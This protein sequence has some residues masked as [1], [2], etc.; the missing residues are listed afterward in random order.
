[1][2]TSTD[3]AGSLHMRS[4]CVPC[5]HRAGRDADDIYA[6]KRN[7]TGVLDGQLSAL[8]HCNQSYVA[9]VAAFL[10]RTCDFE[11]MG[12]SSTLL[13]PAFRGL[14]GLRLGQISRAQIARGRQKHAT[15]LVSSYASHTPLILV[16]LSGKCCLVPQ[17]VYIST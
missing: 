13:S 3:G 2:R 14:R 8:R 7:M 5:S 16:S 12:L 11:R 4:R 15:N 6:V 9:A 1:M 17:H 10:P